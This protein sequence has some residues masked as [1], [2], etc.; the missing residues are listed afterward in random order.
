[1]PMQRQTAARVRIVDLVSGEWVKKD[2][3]E[4]SYVVT[5]G[6]ENVSRAR[7][8][9][10]IVSRFDSED[11]NFSS[12]TL[13]DATA[14]LRVKVWKE[15][16]V[17]SGFRAGDLVSVIGKVREYGGEIYVVP[18]IVTK[19]TPDE[20]SLARLEIIRKLR[21]KKPAEGAGHREKAHAVHEAAKPEPVRHSHEDMPMAHAG[22]KEASAATA[23]KKDEESP[24]KKLITIIEKSADGIRYADLLKES[25]LPEEDIEDVINEL[26]GEGICYEPVPGKIKKI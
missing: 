17:L 10:T 2:G 14:T 18:E 24:R 6:K 11:G 19:V 22:K 16:E 23:V 26:L 9:A 1:M 8:V 25:G 21:S 7:I 4:P 15:I 3:M 5:P 13:D 20:E 12:V